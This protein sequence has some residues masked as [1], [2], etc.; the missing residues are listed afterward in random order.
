MNSSAIYIDNQ[1]IY[2]IL[3]IEYTSFYTLKK[4]KIKIKYHIYRGFPFS[5][6]KL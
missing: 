4:I 2:F 6:N 1:L 3:N 5:G